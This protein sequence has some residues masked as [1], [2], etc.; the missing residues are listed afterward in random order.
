MGVDYLFTRGFA[1]GVRDAL[2]CHEGRFE[3]SGSLCTFRRCPAGLA[4][5]CHR[6]YAGEGSLN[7]S[8]FHPRLPARRHLLDESPALT[9]EL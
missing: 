2:A 8:R 6:R 4:Q 3:P 7:S 1:G 9:I 5:G